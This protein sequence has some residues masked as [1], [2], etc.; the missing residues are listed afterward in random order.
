MEQFYEWDERY[1][2]IAEL[3]TSYLDIPWDKKGLEFLKTNPIKNLLMLWQ[4]LHHLVREAQ[5]SPKYTAE[6]SILLPEQFC[7]LTWKDFMTWRLISSTQDPKSV[8]HTGTGHRGYFQQ[9]SRHVSNQNA[10]ELLAFKKG[11]QKRSIPVY[12]SEG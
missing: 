2:A 9:D 5:G 10:N 8:S 3:S 4:Y 12:Y 7:Q 11:C 1:L 6:F